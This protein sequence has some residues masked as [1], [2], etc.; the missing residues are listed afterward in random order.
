APR[1]NR[2]GRVSDYHRTA[3]EEVCLLL[4]V[5]TRSAVNQIEAIAAVEGVDGIFIGPSDLAADIGHLADTRHPEV[6]AVIAEACARFGA[7]A[8]AAGMLSGNAEDAARYFDMGF[9]FVAAGSD[10]GIMAQNA[11]ARA[12]ELRKHLAQTALPLSPR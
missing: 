2:Y 11:A 10:L 4:Q 5:E 6:Q 12:T 1:A 3:H 7:R 9:T 8:K